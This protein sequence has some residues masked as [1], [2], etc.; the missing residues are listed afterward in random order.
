MYRRR[1][2]RQQELYTVRKPQDLNRWLMNFWLRDAAE[3]YRMHHIDMLKII[4]GTMLLALKY[5]LGDTQ[6]LSRVIRRSL[7][8]RMVLP[9]FTHGNNSYLIAGQALT[10]KTVKTALQTVKTKLKEL[11]EEKDPEVKAMNKITLPPVYETSPLYKYLKNLPPP[12]RRLFI[13]GM[14]MCLQEL[15]KS[16]GTDILEAIREAVE[17]STGSKLQEFMKSLYPDD[18]DGI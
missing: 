16:T 3:T 15:S 2:T 7:K 4:L 9:V 8:N 14:M 12:K 17:L 1:R 10:E 13:H 11:S 18:K 5:E 6:L